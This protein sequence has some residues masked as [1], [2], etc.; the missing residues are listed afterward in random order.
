MAP[1][2]SSTEALQR[3]QLRLARSRRRFY[4]YSAASRR[5]PGTRRRWMRPR[6]ELPDGPDIASGFASCNNSKSWDES[7]PLRGKNPDTIRDEPDA[8]HRS[9]RTGICSRICAEIPQFGTRWL[10]VSKRGSTESVA[11]ACVSY[12]PKVLLELAIPCFEGQVKT[13]LCGSEPPNVPNVAKY[14]KNLV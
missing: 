11:L 2:W 10:S 5:M 4:S 14:H 6:A 9:G 8:C 12:P 13:R 7:L 1:I 3:R